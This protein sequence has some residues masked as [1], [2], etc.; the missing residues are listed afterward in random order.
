MLHEMLEFWVIYLTFDF[1]QVSQDRQSAKDNS[2]TRTWWIIQSLKSSISVYLV[3]SIDYRSRWQFHFK[4]FRSKWPKHDW[5][6]WPFFLLLVNPIFRQDNRSYCTSW[7]LEKYYNLVNSWFEL[8]GFVF[9]LV[10]VVI[11]YFYCPRS[12]GI[13]LSSLIFW[14]TSCL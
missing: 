14:A 11:S 13:F 9:E 1:F 4:L 5:L 2:M 6:S 12:C 8:K 10:G 3:H 7:D